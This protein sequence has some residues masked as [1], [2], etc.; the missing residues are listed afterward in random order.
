MESARDRVYM[1]RNDRPTRSGLV[2]QDKCALT[3][4]GRYFVGYWTLRV[5]SGRWY[6]VSWWDAF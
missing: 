1:S 2:R 5:K 6:L 4:G 3:P